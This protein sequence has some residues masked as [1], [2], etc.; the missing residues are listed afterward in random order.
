MNRIVC[1]FAVCC[2]IAVYGNAEESQRSKDLKAILE[3]TLLHPQTEPFLNIIASQAAAE[4]EKKM[5][6]GEMVAKFRAAFQEEATHAKFHAPFASF[7]DE[8]VA[9]LRK[10]HENGVFQKYSLTAGQAFQ[11]NLAVLNE[12]FVSIVNQHGEERIASELL[13]ITQAN[14]Q[15]EIVEST[16]PIIIDVYSTSCPPCRLMEPIIEDLHREYKDSIRFVKINCDTEQALA[17]KLGVKQLPTLLFIKP[18]EENAS[19]KTIG[20][21]PKKDFQAKITEFLNNQKES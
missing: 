5:D 9:E 19:M 15:K 8:E 7:S 3:Q 4:T 16:K 2:L 11:Q 20:F 21:T 6:A 1:F 17:R 14:Y 13:E 12:F 18:G 10:I